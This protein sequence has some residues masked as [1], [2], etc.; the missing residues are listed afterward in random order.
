M[1]ANAQLKN[2]AK[3]KKTNSEMKPA[4]PIMCLPHTFL[5]LYGT[6]PHCQAILPFTPLHLGRKETVL[7]LMLVN[8]PPLDSP[9]KGMTSTDEIITLISLIFHGLHIQR[10]TYMMHQEVKVISQREGSLPWNFQ[11]YL[12]VLHWSY[13]VHSPQHL[14]YTEVYTEIGS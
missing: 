7:W 9:D 5:C 14:C 6:L 4:N 12:M 11:S 2:H 10:Q 13:T 3:G 8:T 1:S